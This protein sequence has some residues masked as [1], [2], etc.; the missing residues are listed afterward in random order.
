LRN[1]VIRKSREAKE[2]WSE[3]E[4]FMKT[5]NRDEAYRILKSSLVSISP[6]PEEKKITMEKC[7]TNKKIQLKDGRNIYKLCMRGKHSKKM[8]QMKTRKLNKKDKKRT[9]L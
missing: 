2:R 1:L 3:I 4:T 7:N 9:L 5:R 6:E 8:V